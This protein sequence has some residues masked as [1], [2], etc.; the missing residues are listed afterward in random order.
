[1]L[2]LIFIFPYYF[3]TK[4]LVLI[5]LISC[6]PQLIINSQQH[7][8][9]AN[10]LYVKPFDNANH[11]LFLTAWIVHMSWLILTFFLTSVVEHLQSSCAIENRHIHV[12]TYSHE[13]VPTLQT[14]I[15]IHLCIICKH[16]HVCP[17]YTWISYLYTMLVYMRIH[18][19]ALEHGYVS[20]CMHIC[21]Q[22][23]N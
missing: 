10:L 11:Y 4:L 3:I 20:I 15:F 6:R 7:V 17:L 5:S 18:M 21:I 16:F 22:V 8:F 23:G 2:I 13:V 14:C 12:N 19:S 9:V 1:M